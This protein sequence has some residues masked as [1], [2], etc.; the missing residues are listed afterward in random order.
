MVSCYKKNFKKIF[1]TCVPCM[2]NKKTKIKHILVIDIDEKKL[3]Q[4]EEKNQLEVKIH[5]VV[6]VNLNIIRFYFLQIQKDMADILAGI[7]QIDIIFILGKYLNIYICV[8][9]SFALVN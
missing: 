7:V 9:S 6:I 4:E 2:Y 3:I 5:I 1:N 8:Q